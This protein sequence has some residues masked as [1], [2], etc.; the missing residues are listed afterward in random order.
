V[1]AD[2]RFDSA[3]INVL[4]PSKKLRSARVQALLSFLETALKT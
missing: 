3:P 1:L 4:V 2:W